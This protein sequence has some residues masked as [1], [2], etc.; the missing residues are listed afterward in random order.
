MGRRRMLCYR[1]CSTID[2]PHNIGSLTLDTTTIRATMTTVYRVLYL[3]IL[4]RVRPHRHYP[5]RNERLPRSPEL[6]GKRI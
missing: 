6:G 4:A 1:Y 3:T 2:N 5:Y